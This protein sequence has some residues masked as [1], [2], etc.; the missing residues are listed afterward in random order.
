MKRN[1]PPFEVEVTEKA[2]VPGIGSPLYSTG[3]W[4]VSQRDFFMEVDGVGRF[5]AHDG[6]KVEY[7]VVPGADRDWVNL[8]LNGQVLVALMHQRKIINFHASSFVHDGRGVMILGETGAGK[9]SL[10]VSFA[11][12]GAGFLSDDL[13]PV[14]FKDSVPY[15]WP[16][17]RPVKLRESTLDQ[18]DI[19]VN[20]L[21]EAE[22]GTGKQY[23]HIQHAGVAEYPL[24]TILKIEVGVADRPEFI[25]PSPMEKF[26]LLRSEICSWEFL[27]GMPETEADYLQKLV[28]IVQQTIIVRVIRPKDI[29]ITELH[30][31]VE[32]FLK[33]R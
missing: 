23:L 17:D 14:I 2:D 29:R 19:G 15:I 8:Y 24:N 32:R 9:S 4:Q 3:N 26:T 18:L 6:N 22:A 1:L 33:L 28:Q 11:L 7:S 21:T 20:M 10:T 5:H 13:T 16:V 31:A 25:V 12:G 30:E 27:S